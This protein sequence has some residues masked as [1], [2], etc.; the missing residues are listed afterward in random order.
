VAL[1]MKA[2]EIVFDS[3]ELYFLTSTCI[4]GF[5]VAIKRL[6]AV[7]ARSQYQI[8][9]VT[10]SALRWQERSFEVLTKLAPLLVKISPE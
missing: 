2:R 8:R 10:T 3:R 7:D 6:M 1:T 5:M 4:N 9:F